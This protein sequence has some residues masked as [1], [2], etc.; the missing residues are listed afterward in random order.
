MTI[1]D[2]FYAY[3]ILYRTGLFRG[4]RFWALAARNLAEILSQFNATSFHRKV[5]NEDEN[6]YVAQ[7]EP[8]PKDRDAFLTEVAEEGVSSS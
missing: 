6:V 5:V 2:L 7:V 4:E 8:K 3:F 1:G